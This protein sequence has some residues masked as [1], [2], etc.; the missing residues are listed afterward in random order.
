MVFQADAE[1]QRL[2]TDA[3]LLSRVWRLFDPAPATAH[4]L[5]RNGRVLLGLPAGREAAT[6]ALRLYQPQRRIARGVVAG[7]RWLIGLGLLDR[8]LPKIRIEGEQ[9]NVTPALGEVT[10]G[11]CGVMLGS[12]EHRVRRAI[13]SYRKDGEWEVAKIAFGEAGASLLEREAK[14]LEGLQHSI[15]GVPR[16]LGLHRG[17]DVTVLRM[18]YLTGR[19]VNPGD[20]ND[21]LNLLDSW[22]TNLPAQP[23]TEFPEW[24]DIES[25]LLGSELGLRAL[26]RLAQE[27]LR[28]AICH[29]DFARWNLLR[30]TN[31]SLM[32]LDWEWGHENGLPGIDLVHY[33]L[34]DARLVKRLGSANSIQQTL[35]ELDSTACRA[36]LQKTGWS[37]DP[38]LPVLACLAY[39]QG[40]GHQENRD[41]LMAALEFAR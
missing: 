29:G 1:T 15:A 28:P 18:P 36:Y 35:A 20:S 13:A 25:A 41:V 8:A 6:R 33:F 40:A 4:L 16:L 2:M 23:I 27:S 14:A 30:T 7:L 3:E 19:P 21:S 17:Q 5:K 24:H 32:V 38:I 11:T 31:D 10:A 39:K 26:R 34:Q 12:P 37:S 22:I 9:E